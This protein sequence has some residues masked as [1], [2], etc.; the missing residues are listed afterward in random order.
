MQHV[1][2]GAPPI[3]IP[4]LRTWMFAGLLAVL[5]A[6]ADGFWLIA[7]QGVVSTSDR[8]EEP[9]M[10]WLRDSAM[11]FPLFL[12]AIIGAFRQAF[13]ICA[14][15][16]RIVQFVASTLLIAGTASVVGNA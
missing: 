11:L 1:I 13:R 9:F 16:S 5:I 4:S 14:G 12:L 8:I 7:I 2:A 3:K 10:R 15:R 6:F